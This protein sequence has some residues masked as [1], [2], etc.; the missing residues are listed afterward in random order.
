MYKKI[1]ENIKKEHQFQTLYKSEDNHPLRDGKPHFIFS[2]EEPR[3]EAKYEMSHDDMVNHLKSKGYKVHELQGKYGGKSEKS[4]LVQN[5]KPHQTKALMNYAQNLGQDSAIYSDGNGSHELHY[6][7]G[8]KAGTHHK[9][10]GTS[11]PTVAPE[12]NFST[13]EDGTMFAH[14]LDW[15]QTHPNDK[16]M[17]RQHMTQA[18]KKSEG[19]QRPYIP[20]QLSKSEETGRETKLIHFSPQKGLK[21]IS[22]EFHGKNVRTTG[23]KGAPEHKLAFYYR[24]GAKPENVV[25]S[26]AQSKYVTKLDRHHKL[27]DLGQDTEGVLPSVKNWADKKQINRGA[28]TNDDI[29]R[30]LKDR[31][32]HGFFNTKSALPDV[33]GMFHEMPVHEEHELHPND[34]KE[35]S[36]KNHHEHEKALESARDHAKQTGHHNPHFLARLKTEL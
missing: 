28:Y 13:M 24:E 1:L 7:N 12:D 18:L 9:G 5:V 21:D 27:Y 25:T 19:G 11:I 14:S 8:D 22:P 26:G 32:Y 31:G 3:H 4:I 29:H 17:L 6:L 34:F 20:A 35:V 23:E 33:V 36:S 2:A 16:S 15:N 30:E 10:F